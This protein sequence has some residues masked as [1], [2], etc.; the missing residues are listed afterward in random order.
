MWISSDHPED[1][2]RN[3]V[4]RQTVLR[5]EKI[6]LGLKMFNLVRIDSSEVRK[7]K[8]FYD[9]LNG[10]K[11]PR[12]VV[13]TPEGKKVGSVEGS[14]ISITKLYSLMKR[15]S[16]KVYKT[17]IDTYVKD[18]VKVL[19]S[20]DNVEVKKASITKMMSSPHNSKSKDA[21]LARQ[22]LELQK[23]EAGVLEKEA[24]VIAFQ[25]KKEY[26]AAPSE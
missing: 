3:K 23:E 14:D 20:I 13:F 24:K 7:G 4:L 10:R 25:L 8:P 2:V 26:L 21:L 6:S 22:M 19:T 17:R 9:V 12:M 18:Y 15:A 11:L 16:S 5:N 1:A